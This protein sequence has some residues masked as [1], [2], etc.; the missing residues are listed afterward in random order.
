V[1]DLIGGTLGFPTQISTI[2][3]F[4][5]ESPF[6]EVDFSF[7]FYK[8]DNWNSDTFSVLI[9]NEVVF[10]GQYAV[11]NTTNSFCGNSSQGDMFQ[12]IIASSSVDSPI[13]NVSFVVNS[14]LVLWGFDGFKIAINRCSATCL[15]CGGY[16]DNDCLGCYPFSIINSGSCSCIAGFYQIIL[17]QCDGWICSYC[18]ICNETCQSCFGSSANNCSQC[19]DNYQLINNSCIK[20]QEPNNY[21]ILIE[22]DEEG[23]NSNQIN[24]NWIISSTS[25]QQIN[26]FIMNCPYSLNMLGGY[27]IFDANTSLNQLINFTIQHH[28]IEI[29]LKLF[30][31]NFSNPITSTFLLDFGNNNNL[32]INGNNFDFTSSFSCGMFNILIFKTLY[33]FSA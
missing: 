3:N 19:Y 15:S 14:S 24:Q 26:N 12:N 9:N 22:L 4:S 6:F 13:I 18:Q 29:Y 25:Q 21:T 11:D 17:T 33:Y 5:N 23:L 20:T 10:V 27:S 30:I 8:I 16:L 7:N 28:A 2:Y 1:T 32:E 31:F